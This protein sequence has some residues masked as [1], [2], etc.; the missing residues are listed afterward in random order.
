MDL[1]AQL[2]SAGSLKSNSSA[3]S[4]I[5]TSAT[6]VTTTTLTFTQ[7]FTSGSNEGLV[8]AATSTGDVALPADR[9]VTAVADAR[10]IVS[11][12]GRRRSESVGKMMMAARRISATGRRVGEGA[13]EAV[14]AEEGDAD[15]EEEEDDEEGTSVA[16]ITSY[17]FM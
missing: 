16:S 7:P 4:P 17:P 10:V 3:S 9:P 14:G 5:S 12:P 8:A 15:A 13:G 11:S 1:V 6:S 2:L